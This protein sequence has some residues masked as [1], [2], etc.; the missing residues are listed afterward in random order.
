MPYDRRSNG[1]WT[2]NSSG[3]NAKPLFSKYYLHV[4]PLFQKPGCLGDF[5]PYY[6]PPPVPG[7]HFARNNAT[8][9]RNVENTNHVCHQGSEN[10]QSALVCGATVSGERYSFERFRPYVPPRLDPTEIGPYL[11]R[12]SAGRFS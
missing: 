10:D 7:T 8:T 5:I 4:Q 6:S 3:L 9:T 11:V 2:V 1:S 12:L